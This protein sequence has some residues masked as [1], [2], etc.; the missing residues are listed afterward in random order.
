MPATYLE[1]RGILMQRTDD[2]P[3]VF[4]IEDDLHLN[5]LYTKYLQ[6]RGFAPTSFTS[7]QGTLDALENESPPDIII[8]DLNLSDGHGGTIL[9]LLTEARY[10][11]VRVIVVSGQMYNRDILVNMH[12]ADYTLM[13]PISPRD[14]VNVAHA[15]L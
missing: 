1:N 6:K 4:V 13:K 9:E 10:H 5:R 15:M 7:I 8:L 2:Q 3:I 11:N 12:R 14:L